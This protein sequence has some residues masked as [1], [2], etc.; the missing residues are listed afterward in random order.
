[1]IYAAASSDTQRGLEGMKSSDI[2]I[3]FVEWK[4]GLSSGTS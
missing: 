4:S 2:T 3:P 1:M